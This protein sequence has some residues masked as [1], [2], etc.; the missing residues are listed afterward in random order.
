M[1]LPAN[2][3]AAHLVGALWPFYLYL[4]FTFIL[5]FT[6]LNSTVRNSTEACLIIFCLSDTG[7]AQWEVPVPVSR[8]LDI[9]RLK[10]H[11]SNGQRI[12]PIESINL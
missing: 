9:K 8:G 4:N 3:K 5:T 7:S 1:Q 12:G 11:L 10:Q 2:R 6:F